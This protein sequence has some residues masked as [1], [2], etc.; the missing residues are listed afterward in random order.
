MT[1]NVRSTC[2]QI[3]YGCMVDFGLGG[4]AAVQEGSHAEE[5]EEALPLKAEKRVSVE[6]SIVMSAMRYRRTPIL[7]GRA[8][9][10]IFHRVDLGLPYGRLTIR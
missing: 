1:H 7:L 10:R 2:P 6:S 5:E 8:L 4:G 9:N 3:G